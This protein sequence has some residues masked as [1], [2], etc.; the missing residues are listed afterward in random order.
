MTAAKIAPEL[1]DEMKG[2]RH[3]FQRRPE[4]GFDEHRT[5]ARI[6]ELLREFSLEG[7]T[8]ISGTGV[9]GVLQRGNGSAS[10]GFRADM[11]ALPITETGRPEWRS[12]HDGVMHACGHD[13]HTSMLLGAAAHLVRHGD[14]NGRVIFIFQ[15]N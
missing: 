1:V 15:P 14:F 6:A 7:H 2:W 13:G 11:D 12:A 9:V 10:I 8:G 4:L 3:D 5:S